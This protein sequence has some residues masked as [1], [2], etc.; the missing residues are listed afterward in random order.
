MLAQNH[1]PH[2]I[3]HDLWGVR[4]RQDA[5]YWM[6]D[7]HTP[8]VIV[9]TFVIP[10]GRILNG[11]SKPELGRGTPP[12]AIDLF[13]QIFTHLDLSFLICDEAIT[14][15]TLEIWQKLAAQPSG[16]Q[17]INFEKPYE[18]PIVAHTA[19][20]LEAFWGPDPKMKH[21]RYAMCK[22]GAD[23]GDILRGKI[24]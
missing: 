17:I 13:A 15:R 1:V 2:E 19:Q 9:K 7:V 23:F 4:H 12:Y 11:L 5:Y 16:V 14:K 24:T 6:G 10:Q 22:P 8:T 20:E 3:A 18:R 21:F